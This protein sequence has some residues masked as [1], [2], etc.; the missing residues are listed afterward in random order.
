[1]TQAR[2]R[3]RSNA[4]KRITVG[5]LVAGITCGALVTIKTTLPV[6]GGELSS[7]VLI[8]AGKRYSLLLPKHLCIW[9]QRIE[10]QARDNSDRYLSRH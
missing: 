1:V 9:L 5:A 8:V 6:G 3:L 2:S 4:L 10:D 7:E